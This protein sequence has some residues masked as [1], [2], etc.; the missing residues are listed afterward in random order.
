MKIIYFSGT[1]NSKYVAQ[2]IASKNDI[3][4][5]IPE[6]INEN[7]YEIND[8]IVGIVSPTYSWGLP[9]IVVD[10]LSKV[11]INA[12][13]IFYISTYGTI[14]GISSKMARKFLPKINAF[15][16]IQM[17]DVWT[18]IFDLS[19]KDKIERWTKNTEKQID[20]VICMVNERKIGD[21]SNRRTLQ[22][23]GKMAYKNYNKMRKTSNF[24]VE[25]SCIGCRLCAKK[26]PIKAIEII[27]KKPV[28][29]KEQC[30]M[31]LGCLHRC[32]KF[33]IQYGN[34]TKKHGQYLNPNAKI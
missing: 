34:K 16:S 24:K 33:A 27:D 11:K 13:Y 25:N 6:L 22:L 8:E 9:S 32:P 2:K 30:V 28:W 5:F 23:I 29:I 7:Q 4:L 26:C 10:Y 12:S 20:K 17:V 21:F 18:P 14:S 19:K 31:C 3:L 15:Y 1:G